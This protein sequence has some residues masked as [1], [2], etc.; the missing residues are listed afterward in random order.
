MLYIVKEAW[1]YL[2]ETKHTFYSEA[3]TDRNSALM[4]AKELVNGEKR[5]FKQIDKEYH[6]IVLA[7]GYSIESTDSEYEYTASVILIEDKLAEEK[8]SG[9]DR[10]LDNLN[11]V[12][13]FLSFK[14]NEIISKFGEVPDFAEVSIRWKEDN[15][16][17]RAVIAFNDK[18]DE[19]V[20]FRV[21]NLLEF[22]LLF[23]K[24]SKEDFVCEN[25]I[26]THFGIWEQ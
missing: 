8:N 7:D 13:H 6:I 4:K 21:S 19:L 24:E 3:F 22:T 20:T 23:F 1:K 11:K 18:H 10:C 9:L 17:E 2:D 14:Y 5:L 16:S 25:V 26:D 15:K 12:Y